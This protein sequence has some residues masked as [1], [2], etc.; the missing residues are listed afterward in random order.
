MIILLDG[1]VSI[2]SKKFMTASCHPSSSSPTFEHF[3][4]P[5]KPFQEGAKNQYRCHAISDDDWIRS[6]L[7]RVIGQHDSGCDFV[8]KRVLRGVMNLT[9]S[10]YFESCKSARRYR[11]LEGISKDFLEHH[12]QLSLKAHDLFLEQ[13]ALK[14]FHLYAGD[15]HFHAASSHD[16]RDSK[17]TKNAIGHLYALNLRN[18]QLSHLALGSDGTKKKPH[19]MGVLKK[20][21]I[22]TLRQGAGKGQKVLYIW[23]R[24]GIDFQQ[25]FHWKN[26]NAIYFLSRVKENMV[27]T[28]ALPIPF[29][30]EDPLN[31][32]V[33]ADENVSNQSGTMIRRVRFRSPDTG[34]VIEFLTNLGAGIAPGIVAQLYFMRWR[35]EKS[36]DEI[37]NKLHETKAWA[38][39]LEAKRMQA[40]FIILAYNLSQLLH[41]QTSQD[42]MNDDPKNKRNSRRKWNLEEASYHFCEQCLRR[43]ASSA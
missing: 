29:D 36:F 25:W 18:Q 7:Q 16:Q 2:F 12:S 10:N 28:Q 14:G 22:A 13:K 9:K 15:G 41:A 20:L 26:N 17:G 38:M 19:D 27:L 4:A 21:D 40:T 3:L 30:R 39:S 42:Q 33:I 5:L 24:A 43:R 11:H 6:G 1:K 32:G 31:A 8:Q 35:V 23:D 37:K 34:E